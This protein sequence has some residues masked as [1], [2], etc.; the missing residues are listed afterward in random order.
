MWDIGHNCAT[1]LPSTGKA[2]SEAP[3]FGSRRKVWDPQCSANNLACLNKMLATQDVLSLVGFPRG[4]KGNKL[5]GKCGHRL[6]SK[7]QCKLEAISK[8]ALQRYCKVCFDWRWY[9]VSAI[10]KGSLSSQWRSSHLLKI[11]QVLA[12]QNC[13][14]EMTLSMN[15]SRCQWRPAPSWGGGQR[16]A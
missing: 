2:P 5:T 4:G 12:G 8:T 16:W 10:I 6:W 13:P 15:N 11:S 14:G 7:I 1:Y 9:P 3:C